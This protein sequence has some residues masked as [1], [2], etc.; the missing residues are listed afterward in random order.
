MAKVPRQRPPGYLWDQPGVPQK[1]WRY[2]DE[3]PDVEDTEEAEHTCQ[4]CAK[5]RV[6]YVH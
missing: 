3:Y 6:R 5:E 1:G 4:M 2:R